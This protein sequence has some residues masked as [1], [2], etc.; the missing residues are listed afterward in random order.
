[1]ETERGAD[2]LECRRLLEG[3]TKSCCRSL[4]PEKR[5]KA[6]LPFKRSMTPLNS[7]QGSLSPKKPAQRSFAV[8]SASGTT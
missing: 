8:W 1:M 5:P 3:S 4:P 2:E 6:L 7:S